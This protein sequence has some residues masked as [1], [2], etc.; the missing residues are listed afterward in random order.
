MVKQVA[1]PIEAG[2]LSLEAAWFGAVYITERPRNYSY[3]IPLRQ[4]ESILYRIEDSR[5]PPVI[6]H[7]LRQL[8]IEVEAAHV[9]E[10]THL[11]L[12]D[13]FIAFRNNQT[14]SHETLVNYAVEVYLGAFE[15]YQQL[16][17]VLSPKFLPDLPLA[18]ILPAR[19]VGVV[20]PPS[21]SSG[22]VTWSWYWEPLPEGSQNELKFMLSDRPV[23]EN[24]PAVQTALEK[25]KTI[26]PRWW[27]HFL[28]KTKR[29]STVPTHWLGIN[30]VTKLAYQWLWDDLKRVAWVSGE[31]D[32]SDV[33][34]WH[35][36]KQTY[37]SGID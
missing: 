14:I 30:P 10:Q 21:S 32:G 5:F 33:A 8:R 20:V 34:Y 2:Y 25:I 23:T 1:I 12:P 35:P 3:P 31:L 7:C 24:E 11:C 19:L 13:S 4:I 22:S 27:I 16:V 9:R 26:Q 37:R 17:K 29:A 6:Q 18:S 28:P 36:V 15:G